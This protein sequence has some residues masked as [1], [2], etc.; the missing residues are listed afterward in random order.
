MRPGLIFKRQ[1][2]KQ[3]KSEENILKIEIKIGRRIRQTADSGGKEREEDSLPL[4][5]HRF[6]L[7]ASSSLHQSSSKR[8]S[9]VLGPRAPASESSQCKADRLCGSQGRATVCLF[10]ARSLRR[11]HRTEVATSSQ[12]PVLAGSGLPLA[13]EC[14][15]RGTEV[16]QRGGGWVAFSLCDHFQPRRVLPAGLLTRP[17]GRTAWT[18][19]SSLGASWLSLLCRCEGCFVASVIYSVWVSD[20]PSPPVWLILWIKSLPLLK[21]LS[22]VCFSRTTSKHTSMPS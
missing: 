21:Y 10:L 2:V 20:L 16:P 8:G 9:C 3:E 4:L 15:A 22:N 13:E 11:P 5:P 14:L 17:L 6:L 1:G 19:P 7:A 12:R 18:P